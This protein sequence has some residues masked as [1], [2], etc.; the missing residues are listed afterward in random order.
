MR[1]LVDT[2]AA[3]AA[4]LAL[5]LPRG[6]PH[7]AEHLHPLLVRTTPPLHRHSTCTARTFHPP[8][9]TAPHTSPR[10]LTLPFHTPCRR[11]LLLLGV[12]NRDV[13]VAFR[14]LVLVPWRSERYVVA[15]TALATATATLAVHRV[16]H[17]TRTG[18]ATIDGEGRDDPRAHTVTDAVEDGPATGEGRG[19]G[20][21]Q[22][23]QGQI[24]KEAP[25]LKCA[26]AYVLSR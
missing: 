15:I 26:T 8:H 3:L 18:R 20:A 4:T 7:Q 13:I 6:G 5:A 25:R 21:R 10:I 16:V 9:R 2:L 1:V 11:L 12:P 23:K 19:G 22:V 14:E 17:A 24:G